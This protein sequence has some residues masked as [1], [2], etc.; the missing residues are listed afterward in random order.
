MREY[1]A[2]GLP[3]P[4]QRRVA[5]HEE[6]PGLQLPGDETYRPSTAVRVDD[7]RRAVLDREF[8]GSDRKHS[9]QH[10]G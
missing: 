6:C 5:V 1:A 9:Q 3:G 2:F 4:P 10:F 7:L 8:F